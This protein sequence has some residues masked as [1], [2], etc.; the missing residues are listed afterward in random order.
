MQTQTKYPHC[1]PRV[2]HLPKDCEFCDMYPALQAERIRDGVNFTGEN[3]PK[4]KPCPAE[5]ARGLKSINS[6]H[7]NVAQ[8]KGCPKCNHRG[9]WINLGLTCPVHGPF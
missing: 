5:T 9:E 3:N 1:D 8:P 6:W 7:G 4:K 2:L